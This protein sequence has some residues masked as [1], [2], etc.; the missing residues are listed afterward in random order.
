MR[1][2]TR[3][4]LFHGEALFRPSQPASHFFLVETG[5][6]QILDRDGH[7]VK[8]QFGNSELFGIPEVLAR[9]Q[10]DLTAVAEGPTVV[11]R[12][13]AEMLFQTL[14]DMP[15]EH[16]RFLRGIAAMA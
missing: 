12:F 14:A 11:R 3:I 4:S 6:I 5:L 15:T 7:V 10:W 8:R 9:G 13:P 2:V 1:G 16:D